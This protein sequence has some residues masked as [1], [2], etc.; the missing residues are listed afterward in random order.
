MPQWFYQEHVRAATTP[1][2]A[3]SWSASYDRA[4][5]ASGDTAAGH[6]CLGAQCF[7]DSH[8]IA[9]ALNLSGALC[10][11]WLAYSTRHVYRFRLQELASH[12]Q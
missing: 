3:S 10:F 7:R 12:V 9:T 6:V 5:A 2:N 11:A 8:F 1:G 4:G